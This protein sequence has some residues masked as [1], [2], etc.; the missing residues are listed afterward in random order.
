[1]SGGLL[2]SFCHHSLSSE[3]KS[4]LAGAWALFYF[5]FSFQW[6]WEFF[7]LGKKCLASSE[8]T[9]LGSLHVS[10]VSD[11][12]NLFSQFSN[13]LH[14]ASVV[15]RSGNSMKGGCRIPWLGFLE[16]LLKDSGRVESNLG[17]LCGGAGCSKEPG[18]LGFF[19]ISER[20]S[21]R[22][23]AVWKER[24]ANCSFY[25]GID[26]RLFSS[27][28]YLHVLNARFV[29]SRVVSFNLLSNW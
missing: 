14:S 24:N 7:L 8:V 20:L 11:L 9:S 19:V 25:N 17:N 6:L 15:T 28:F 22:Y 3:N 2:H 10:V 4:I 1:M 27:G 16:S 23:T 29:I 21:K 13:S 18:D 26:S 12:W 5:V